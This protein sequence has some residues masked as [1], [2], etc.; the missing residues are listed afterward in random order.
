MRAR[1]FITELYDPEGKYTGAKP[2]PPPPPPRK[3]GGPDWEGHDNPLWREFFTLMREKL[4]ER[5]F[6]ILYPRN[7]DETALLLDAN[8]PASMWAEQHLGAM[9]IWFDLNHDDTATLHILAW[10]AGMLPEKPTTAVHEEVEPWE[11]RKFRIR[12]TD[13]EFALRKISTIQQIL[14]SNRPKPTN[15]SVLTEGATDVLYHATSSLGALHILRDGE[16]KL[17]ASSGTFEHEYTV[18]NRPF[19]LSTSRSKVGDYHARY[20]SIGATVFELDG[21]WLGQRY[22]VRPMDYWGSAWVNN[23]SGRTRESEDRVYSRKNT[24]PLTPVK[25][26]H[27]Y[28]QHQTPEKIERSLNP[29]ARTRDFAR[30]DAYRWAEIREMSQLAEQRNILVY[31]YYD[32]RDWKTQN[33]ARAEYP[34]DVIELQ[35]G[36]EREPSQYT[37]S[38]TLARL[39]ELIT[40]QPGDALSSDA[41][42]LLYNIRWYSDTYKTLETDMHNS[43][44]PSSSDYPDAVRVAN[45]MT[46]HKLKN[47][48]E[49]VDALKAKWGTPK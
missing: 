33:T 8:W 43:R 9:R 23:K 17:T 13:F 20:P 26:I 15:E 14:I 1:D 29:D 38:P 18:R 2:P 48:R 11:N 44:K 10:K 22:A 34:E 25:S 7:P 31:I 16:F 36:L 21:R 5:D 37:M 19:F 24:I 6:K 42:R 40:A 39:V 12:I 28:I 3:S 30:A 27:V 35:H 4:I 47:M 49:L 45:Y 46:Q 41:D 32:L